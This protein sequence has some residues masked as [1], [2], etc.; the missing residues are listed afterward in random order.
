FLAV[1]LP[2][3]AKR[4]RERRRRDSGRLAFMDALRAYFEGRY[5]RAEKA[6]VAAL[7]AGELPALSAVIAARAAHEMRAF[8]A[9]DRYLARV[10]SGSA[11]EDYLRRITQA[12]L[13][14]DE[15]RYHDGLAVLHQLGEG[16]TAALRLELKAQQMAKNWD[17]VLALLPQLE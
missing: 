8:E 16:H 7:D 2:A 5:G 17:R 11:S 6:A 9:R 1:A 13:L 4:F 15:R 14:L 10:E 3:E 12:E